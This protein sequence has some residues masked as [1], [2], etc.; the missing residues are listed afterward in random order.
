MKQILLLTAIFLT[1]CGP[2]D[3]EKEEIAQASCNLIDES[4]N[5]DDTVRIREI[6]AARNKIGEDAFLQSDD[7]IKESL[8]YGLCKELVLKD[9]LYTDKLVAAIEAEANQLQKKQEIAIIACNIMAE[10]K[11]MD[12]AIRIREINNARAEMGEDAFLQ[13]DNAIKESFKYGLCED[14]VLNDLHYSVKLRAAIEVEAVRSQATMPSAWTLEVA[15]YERSKKAEALGLFK[16]LQAQGYKAFVDPVQVDGNAQ[17]RVIIG[18]KL[19]K[20]RLLATQKLIDKDWGTRS[21][22]RKYEP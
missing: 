21:I 17:F 8:K 10:S 19:S 4:K 9:I 20:E 7:A 18:P 5:I 15:T 1:A 14:L 12:G 2:S 13:S 6:N 22:I 3:Q 11:N 16:S